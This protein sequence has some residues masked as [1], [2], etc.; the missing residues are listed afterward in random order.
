L[1]GAVQDLVLNWLPLIE[2]AVF[3]FN[4]TVV[5]EDSDCRRETSA[6]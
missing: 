4:S 6:S 2:I 5:R 3:D 1:L